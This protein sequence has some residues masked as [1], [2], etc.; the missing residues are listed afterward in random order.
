M[1]YPVRFTILGGGNFGLALSH[2]LARNGIPSTLLLRNA[3]IA[4]HINVHHEHPTYLKGIKLPWHIRATT[5]AK[6]A[7]QDATYVIHAVPVQYSRAFLKKVASYIPPG[8]PI[9]SVSKGIETSSLSLMTDILAET[10]GPERSYAFLS[11]PSFAREIAQNMATAVVIA[12]DDS[13]L[14]ND[15]ANLLSSPSF[16]CFTSKDVIGVEVGGAVKNVIAI[17]AGMSE[18]LGL[19]TNAMAGL[20]TRGCVEMKRIAQVLGGKPTTLSGLSGVGDTFGT[21][22]GPLSRN[23]NFGIR[24]GKGETMEEILASSTEVAEGVDTALALAN[25]I[26]K[27][28]KS[29]R[30]DLKYAIIFGV[31]DILQGFRS[32]REGLE[33]LMAMPLRAEMYD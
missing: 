3:E 16:R 6:D 11:G 31:S 33:D 2:V 5:D 26:K 32:P 14:A 15:L 20:V 10:C 1:P 29:Y 24:L 7:L 8:A 17:A 9:L 13:Q 18:G 22:F 28:D 19:G 27:I 25:L 30:I 23:R 4:E 21:C 12:S